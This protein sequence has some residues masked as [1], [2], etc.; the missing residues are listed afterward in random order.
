M[1]FCNDS[2][3]YQFG[4]ENMWNLIYEDDS[5]QDLYDEEVVYADNLFKSRSAERQ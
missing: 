2:A 4:G 3:M 1:E 5:E